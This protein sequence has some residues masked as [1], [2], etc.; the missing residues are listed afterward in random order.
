[1]GALILASDE[2]TCLELVLVYETVLQFLIGVPAIV[3]NF[4]NQGD[5]VTATINNDSTDKICGDD[6]GGGGGIIN[7]ILEQFSSLGQK[8]QDDQLSTHSISND[9]KGAE[10]QDSGVDVAGNQDTGEGALLASFIV[11]IALVAV[12][13]FVHQFPRRLRQDDDRTGDV[14]QEVTDDNNSKEVV[15]PSENLPNPAAVAEEGNIENL[16]Q[17]QVEAAEEAV[18]WMAFDG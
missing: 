11:L 16:L 7:S 1:M 14:P 10:K 9:G 3:S 18:R 17:Q 2:G 5:T 6:E 15:E 12:C 8:S 4:Y 13:F